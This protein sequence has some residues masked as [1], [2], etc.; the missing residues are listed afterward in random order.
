MV[1]TCSAAQASMSILCKWGGKR[2]NDMTN[3]VNYRSDRCF[4]VLRYT[5]HYNLLLKALCRLYHMSFRCRAMFVHIWQFLLYLSILSMMTVIFFPPYSSSPY[6]VFNH[7]INRT[8]K[9]QY[10]LILFF[11]VLVWVSYMGFHAYMLSVLIQD[12][13]N[14]L[15]LLKM[16]P[17]IYIFGIAVIIKKVKCFHN[18]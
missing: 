11:S 3:N 9:S 16:T 17:I 13:L 4:M 2:V 5:T 18:L 1:S 6:Q 8:V 15:K 12:N 14:S 10:M 7:M